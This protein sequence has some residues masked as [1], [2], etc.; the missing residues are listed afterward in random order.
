MP[1]D[2]AKEPGRTFLKSNNSA[3]ANE[4]LVSLLTVFSEKHEFFE[5][6]Y[7][8]VVNQ[9]FPWFEWIIVDCDG[10]GEKSKINSLIKNDKR[11]KIITQKQTEL[12]AAY[13]QCLAQAKGEILIFLESVDVVE[14]QFVEY[15]YWA[16]KR[17]EKASWAYSDKVVFYDDEQRCRVYFSPDSLK[18]KNIALRCAAY[19]KSLFDKDANLIEGLEF[20]PDKDWLLWLRLLKK[21]CAPVHVCQPL[22]WERYRK[23]VEQNTS[24]ALTEKIND[25]VKQIPSNVDVKP[26]L[27]PEE[28][29][30]EYFLPLTFNID[31]EKYTTKKEHTHILLLTAHV[32]RGGAEV[33]NMELAKQIDKTKYKFSIIAMNYYQNSEEC[34]QQLQETCANVLVLCDF[35]SYH[36]WPGFL[37]YYIKSR[38]VDALWFNNSFY[39]CYLTPWLRLEFRNLAMASYVHADSPYWRGGGYA[40]VSAA[41]QEMME[42][43]VTTNRPALMALLEKYELPEEVCQVSYIGAD[44]IY[45]DPEK[46]KFGEIRKKYNLGFTRP[47]V[48]FLARINAEKRP[49]LVVSIA[50]KLVQKLPDICFLVVGEGLMKDHMMNVVW[51]M[52]LHKNI[53]FVG[54]QEDVRPCY[55]DADIFLVTSLM[56]GVTQTTFEAM[57]MGLPVVSSDVGDQGSL[58]SDATG[59]LVPCLQDSTADLYNYNYDV[60]EVDNYANAIYELLRD[61]D[62]RLEMGKKNR[63]LIVSKYSSAHSARDMERL[64]DELLQNEKYVEKRLELHNILK[65]IP[66]LSGEL[67]AI[68]FTYELQMTIRNSVHHAAG[69]LAANKDQLEMLAWYAKFLT[70]K[71]FG[72]LVLKTMRGF[73]NLYSKLR[74]KNS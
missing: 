13:R 45:N 35:L 32:L 14:S 50:Q 63:E 36:D 73:Y 2:F 70:T 71:R 18:A 52:Q 29:N 51:N 4:P 16:L 64:T 37:H 22:F 54:S 5:Q 40:R 55:K 39:G 17:N 74:R 46:I 38:G 44:T 72:R 48:L 41:F 9:T 66:R 8:S 47:I 31:Y 68:F 43:T 69:A 19:R 26:I 62:A 21:K 67:A 11:I 23:D 24:K 6:T 42:L 10:F 56:E 33:F 7:R 34:M 59:K 27:Y 28:N 3:T 1:F 20:S 15:L 65:K 12:T 30:K 49:M 25:T 53:V 61:P 60:E 57:S 58:V